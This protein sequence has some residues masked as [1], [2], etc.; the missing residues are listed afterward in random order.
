MSTCVLSTGST[1][2]VGLGS[3]AAPP[4][5]P[6]A[7]ATALRSGQDDVRSVTLRPIASG[8]WRDRVADVAARFGDGASGPGDR[9]HAIDLP[10]ALAALR[11]RRQSGARVVVRA[12]LSQP[13]ANGPASGLWPVVVRA[14]DG[15]V[16]PTSA[17][18]DAA[19]AL[20]ADRRRV[21]V[22]PDAALV[23]AEV[24]AAGGE[25]SMR[26]DLAPYVLG[27]SGAPHDAAVRRELLRLLVMQPRLRL[28]LTAPSADDLPDRTA[29]QEQA[30][31]AG[32]LQRVVVLGRLAGP[33]LAAAVDG[34]R[35]V[36]ATRSDPTS[37]LAPLVAMHRARAV[38]AVRSASTADVVVDGVTGL[39]TDSSRGLGLADAVDHLVRDEFR[40]L[41]W[42]V[43]GR[44]RV[45]H[46]YAPHQIGQALLAAHDL[47]AA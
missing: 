21:V 10:A 20:G 16:A 13:R 25:P 37:A 19:V 30:R 28:V 22:C 7:V 5:L 42:G 40:L 31:R 45:A 6:A 18:A 1:L 33:E 9:V 4:L 43:A 24:A 15:I 8:G 47:A 29:L 44:D 46:R 14:A 34:A 26:D 27:L 23:A 36:V 32:V 38:V 2:A 41:A 11:A 12:Q 3:V 35:L 17:D 39:L